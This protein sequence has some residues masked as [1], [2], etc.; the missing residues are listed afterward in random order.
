MS[1]HSMSAPPSPTD[2]TEPQVP[3]RVQPFWH[4]DGDIILSVESKDNATEQLFKVHKLF[5]VFKSP[6]FR[7]M[8][9]VGREEEEQ[10]TPVVPLRDDSVDDVCA[11]LRVIYEGFEVY[12]DTMP[13][14]T[15]LGILRLSHKYQM[16]SLRIAIIRL[17]KQSWPLNRQE[18]RSLWRYRPPGSRVLE[19]VKLINTAWRTHTYQLLPTAF[20][21][22]AVMSLSQDNILSSYLQE[23]SAGDLVRL[24]TGKDKMQR[25]FHSLLEGCVR[26]Q[27][28]LS[29]ISIWQP[30][31]EGISIAM[32]R[33]TYSECGHCR[34]WSLVDTDDSVVHS[35]PEVFDA[36]RSIAAKH[37]FGGY[38]RL[39]DLCENIIPSTFTGAGACTPCAEWMVSILENKAKEIWWNIPTDFELPGLD[40]VEYNETSR[41][42]F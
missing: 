32:Y 3:P 41:N 16:D 14:D 19:C 15:A 31:E 22:L 12:G 11:L 33:Q 25:R 37:V 1:I 28:I 36:W 27:D 38:L 13:F 9:A 4:E 21:E 10:A 39:D 18:Y 20:Y 42:I 2:F 6:V 17:L 5:L 24:I 30:E 7:D 26:D 8:I 23:L 29:S 35:C 40:T 34:H